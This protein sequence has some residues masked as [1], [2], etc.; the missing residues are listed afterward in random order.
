MAPALLPLD[1]VSVG[2][3]ELEV[4][5]ELFSVVGL[6]GV[7]AGVEEGVEKFFIEKERVLVAE[8]SEQ[9]MTE[10]EFWPTKVAQ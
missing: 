9:I 2:K 5:F 7:E 1:S 3:E 6:A 4:E 8:S 10:T